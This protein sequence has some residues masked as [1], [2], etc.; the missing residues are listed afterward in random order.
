MAPNELNINRGGKTPYP[1]FENR[2]ITGLGFFFFFIFRRQS[3]G[4]YY[5]IAPPSA[6]VS[7]ENKGVGGEKWK[8]VFVFFCGRAKSPNPSHL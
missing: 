5:I 6:L 3:T 7:S 8:S 4:K 1:A 2:G